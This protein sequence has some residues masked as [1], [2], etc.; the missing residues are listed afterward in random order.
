MKLKDNRE[1][2]NELNKEWQFAYSWGKFN[3][4]MQF[5]GQ[6]PKLEQFVNLL[7]KPK[8]ETKADYQKWL[9]CSY[10]KAIQEYQQAEDKILFKGFE[11]VRFDGYYSC[12][13]KFGLTIEFWDSGSVKMYQT[14]IKTLESFVGCELTYNGIKAVGYDF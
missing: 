5:T 6:E 4:Q 9:L 8:K 10:S 11:Y 3:L 13:N 7:E 2:W 1:Y 14:Y 12:V